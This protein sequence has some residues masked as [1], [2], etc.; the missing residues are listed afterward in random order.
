MCPPR[1]ESGERGLRLPEEKTSEESPPALS[2]RFYLLNEDASLGKHIKGSLWGLLRKR[3]CE[4]M[5][6]GTIL[7]ALAVG[8]LMS[9]QTLGSVAVRGLWQAEIIQSLS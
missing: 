4:E 2:Y 5:S 8:Q 7:R 3:R 1:C 6:D 9:V